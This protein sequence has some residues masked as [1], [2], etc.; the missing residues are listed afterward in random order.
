MC[1]CVTGWGG[2]APGVE[3]WNGQWPPQSYWGGTYAYGNQ[4]CGYTQPGNQ[5]KI[6]QPTQQDGGCMGMVRT[7]RTPPPPAHQ[8]ATP[9]PAAVE[10]LKDHGVHQ[11]RIQQYCQAGY[12][13]ELPAVVGERG[14]QLPLG[15]PVQAQTAHPP[16]EQAGKLELVA[17]NVEATASYSV[18]KATAHQNVISKP[19]D[20]LPLREQER[21]CGLPPPEPQQQFLQTKHHNVGQYDRSWEGRRETEGACNRPFGSPARKRR[22]RWEQPAGQ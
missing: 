22:S 21:P 14:L 5:M 12:T 3:Q 15:H 16:P 20:A 4:A 7:D 8:D 18:E 6:Q 10:G 1:L 11:P 9:P 19:Q 17:P 13:T 2:G